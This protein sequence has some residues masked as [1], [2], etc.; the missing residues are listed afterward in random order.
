MLCHVPRA[1]RPPSTGTVAYGEQPRLLELKGLHGSLDHLG[2]G[3]LTQVGPD[4]AQPT[5]H[6]RLV[7]LDVQDREPRQHDDV[8]TQPGV[9][10]VVGGAQVEQPRG[11]GRLPRG[12]VRGTHGRRPAGW[13]ERTGHDPSLPQ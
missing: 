12:G 4:L 11:R 8:A 6:G 13:G 9:P 3:D 7:G 2:R 5:A 10:P 1:R